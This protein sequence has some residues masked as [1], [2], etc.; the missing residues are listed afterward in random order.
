VTYFHLVIPMQT[1][2]TLAQEPEPTGSIQADIPESAKR[3]YRVKATELGMSNSEYLVH[4]LTKFT[5][6]EPPKEPSRG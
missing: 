4:L 1:Q 2:D 6:Y 3:H 5:G